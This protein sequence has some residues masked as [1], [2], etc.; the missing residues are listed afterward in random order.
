MLRRTKLFTPNEMV[1][2]FRRL[3]EEDAIE[4]ALA[5]S[6]G[7]L[8][9]YFTVN[10]GTSSPS[11]QRTVRGSRRGRAFRGCVASERVSTGLD[12]QRSGPRTG[13]L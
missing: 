7:P 4:T 11:R 1:W 6:L 3:A 2:P 13:P 10:V 9:E 5:R 12:E 8:R